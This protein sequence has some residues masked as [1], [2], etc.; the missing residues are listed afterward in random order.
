MRVLLISAN[1]E[2][3]NTPV[4]P[5]GLACAAAAADGQEH[6]LKMLNLMM[7]T[8]ALKALH[9]TFPLHMPIRFAIS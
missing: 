7:Q 4:L 9:L 5:L 8:D 2:Q 3:I 1:T 6:K